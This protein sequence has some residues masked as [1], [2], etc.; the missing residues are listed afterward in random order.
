M[1]GPLEFQHCGEWTYA[2]KRVDWL[3]LDFSS[4]IY[5]YLHVN[6]QEKKNNWKHI[7]GTIFFCL[8]KLNRYSQI[9]NI[10]I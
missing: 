7:G 8:S 1:I 10:M 3:I 9:A 2:K 6:V 5:I 4:E